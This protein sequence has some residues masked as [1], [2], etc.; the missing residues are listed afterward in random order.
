MAFHYGAIYQNIHVDN[1]SMLVSFCAALVEPLSDLQALREH[2]EKVCPWIMVELED[3]E[4]IEYYIADVLTG[5]LDSKTTPFLMQSESNHV[6]MQTLH[7][8][9]MT[10]FG[11]IQ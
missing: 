10:I 3:G 9:H 11:K 4:V 1:H 6:M 8:V 2:T 5:C 7:I